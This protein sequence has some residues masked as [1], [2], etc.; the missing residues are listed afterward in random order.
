MVGNVR[1]GIDDRSG[2]IRSWPSLAGGLLGTSA[3]R[4]VLPPS[5][6]PPVAQSVL[7]FLPGLSDRSDRRWMAK[8]LPMVRIEPAVIRSRQT[9]RGRADPRGRGIRVNRLIWTRTHS[10][11]SDG[12]L[13]D[14]L[15]KSITLKAPVFSGF[16]DSQSSLRSSHGKPGETTRTG[17][18]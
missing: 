17:C 10:R 11:L 16:H 18:Q 13:T 9:Q 5:V 1:S 14:S 6:V 12:F 7:R 15:P 4:N 8:N 3:G 2:E